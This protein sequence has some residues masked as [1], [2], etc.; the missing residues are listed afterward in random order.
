MGDEP[1]LSLESLEREEA[2]LRERLAKVVAARELLQEL[3]QTTSKSGYV[4]YPAPVTSAPS[5][6]S[7]GNIKQF[8]FDGTFASLI[9]CYR[10]DPRSTY[11]Q[12]K[13]KVRQGYDGPL[14][15]LV[16]E[17]GDERVS[18][19]NAPRIQHLYDS[20]WA[21][22]GKLATG[23]GIIAKLRLLSTFGSVVLDDDDCTRL[24][25]ILSNMR[26]PVAKGRTEV[27]TIDHARAIRAAAHTQFNWPSIAIAQAFQ[28]ELPKL[29][30]VG[31]IGEWVPLSEPGESDIIKGNEK[32]LRGLR[33]SDIDEKSMTLRKM[34]T[35]GRQNKPK[36]HV[37]NLN[38]A[39]MVMEELNR[40]P[41]WARTGPIV[42]C[43]FSRLPWTGNEFRRK[44][45]K[46]AD[47]AGVPQSVKNMDSARPESEE[48]ETDN[49]MED[50][51]K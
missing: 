28:F 34:L 21:A 4:T 42:V 43:E 38:R 11:H 9:Y 2:R 37:F 44:W 47:K 25:A 40:I 7:V 27:L 49:D 45:R 32:W 6:L 35:S 30:Q 39:A 8:G 10:H 17:V 36:E 41:P 18:D 48:M 1:V 15:R 46:V 5:V 13:F 50:L 29:K 14:N 51:L 22:G 3:S 12:L 19:W 33:W 26:F 23:H 31:V 16:E 24:S 20:S